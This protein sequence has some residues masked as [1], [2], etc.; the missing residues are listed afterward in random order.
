MNLYSY[1]GPVTEFG[2][3]IDNHWSGSTYA[4]SAKKAKSNLA[5]QY[6]KKH[7]KLPAAK[8]DLPGEIVWV[9]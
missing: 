3:C 1:S 8:I 4:P 7:N 2:R 5:Y 9:A 6:K